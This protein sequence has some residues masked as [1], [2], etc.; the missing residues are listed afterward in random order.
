MIPE[1][2]VSVSP[3]VPWPVLIG[4]IGMVTVLTLWAY[5][6]RLQGTSGALALV[7]A[8]AAA[9]GD[10][11]LPAGRAAALRGAQGEGEAASLADLPGRPKPAA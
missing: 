8:L 10:P 2:S 4:V 3:I 6:R 9:A 1:F 7:R 5:R 11:A